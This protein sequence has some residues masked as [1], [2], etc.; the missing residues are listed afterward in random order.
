MKIDTLTLMEGS[1]VNNMTVA[2]GTEFPAQADLGELF[3]R[4]EVG[5]NFLYVYD[6]AIW[7][8]VVGLDA[9]G[10]IPA[11]FIDSTEFQELLVSGTN[12]KTVN[13][14]SILGSGDIVIEGGAGVGDVPT[15]NFRNLLHNGN[16][17]FWDYAYSL[18]APSLTSTGFLANR[19]R[20][21]AIGNTTFT[22]TRQSFAEGQIDVPH[23]RY[24]HRCAV[25]GGSQSVSGFLLKQA[26]EGVRT[27]AGGNVCLSFYAE[28]LMQTNP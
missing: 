5:G 21:F 27:G 16:F 13:G 24:Y 26:I 7:S 19:W 14:N 12:I 8:L 22:A 25:A 17:L 18:T 9:N 1:S 11:T 15:A 20:C 4:E 23:A 10:K 28:A 2:N 3:V 6:G